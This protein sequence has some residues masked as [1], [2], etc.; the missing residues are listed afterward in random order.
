LE[1]EMTKIKGILERNFHIA[2][3]WLEEL[4]KKIKFER[5]V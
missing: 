5:K 3:G 1:E 4:P 2:L